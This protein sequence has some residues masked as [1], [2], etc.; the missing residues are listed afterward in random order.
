MHCERCTIGAQRTG[1]TLDEAAVLAVGQEFKR[2]VP[3]RWQVE[4][5][6]LTEYIKQTGDLPDGV[7]TR[8]IMRVRFK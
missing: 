5:K 4:K 8:S 3:A 2:L 7:E 1:E 6:A